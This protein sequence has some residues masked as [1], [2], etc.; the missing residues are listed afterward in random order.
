MWEGRRIRKLWDRL[1][2]RKLP[3]FPSRREDALPDIQSL[4]QILAIQH[5]NGARAVSEKPS[6]AVSL[7]WATSVSVLPPSTATNSV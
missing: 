7:Q 5:V 1:P 6:M 3:D 4:K 2:L